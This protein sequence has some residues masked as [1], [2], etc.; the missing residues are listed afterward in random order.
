MPETP[1]CIEGR[2][3]DLTDVDLS[4]PMSVDQALLAESLRHALCCVGGPSEAI[5]GYITSG[6]CTK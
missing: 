1:E 5:A 6:D 2:L 3:I 4:D